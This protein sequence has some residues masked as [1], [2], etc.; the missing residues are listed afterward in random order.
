MGYKIALNLMQISEI[1]EADLIK[2][3]KKINKSKANIFYFADSLGSLNPSQVAKIIKIIKLNWKN[4]LGI[5]A[6]D[7]LGK[8]I[9]NTIEAI[10]S[11][12]KWV[13]CTVTGMGRGTG[14]YTNRKFFS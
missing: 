3:S 8:A 10:K 9:L 5:H 7:N 6:H 1:S 13:D 12:V 14:K 11:G 2:A 4:D